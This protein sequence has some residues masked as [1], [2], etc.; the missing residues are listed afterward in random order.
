VKKDLEARGADNQVK[1]A[2]KVAAGR[3]RNAVGALTGKTSEQARG[4]AKELEGRVQKA[5][6]TAQSKTAQRKADK[7]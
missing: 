3:L 1:G 6:G 5:I 4:K 2:A 7:R